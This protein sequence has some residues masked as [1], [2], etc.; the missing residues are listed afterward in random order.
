MEFEG[1]KFSEIYRL[2]LKD[3]FS[4][5]QKPCGYRLG[6]D[7]GTSFTKASY[8]IKGDFGRV[9]FNLG[10]ETK[11]S[12]VY[13]DE[14][15][16]T[17]S[18]FKTSDSLKRIHYFKATMSGNEEYELLKQKKV[19]EGIKNVE[20]KE[21]FEFLCSVFFIANMI[22]YSSLYVAR[23][24]EQIPIPTVSMGIPMSWNNEQ[25]PVYNKALHTA[26][27][28][29]SESFGKDITVMSLSDIYDRYKKYEPL[30][31]NDA[32]K[33]KKT[34]S[35]N[36]TIPEVVTEMN[37]LL[38]LKSIPLGDYCIIDIGGGTADFAFITKESF[39]LQKDPLF[40]CKYALVRELGDQVRKVY[41]Y[42]KKEDLYEAKFSSAFNECCK[43]AKGKMNKKGDMLV[44][45]YLL[46][47]GALTDGAYYESILTSKENMKL[48]DSMNV[49]IEVVRPE[50]EAEARHIIAD[51]LSL[52]DHGLKMLAG[53]PMH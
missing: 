17:L 33:P 32:F 47:G 39:I 35:G 53:I 40:D 30:F 29:L 22:N 49:K 41:R 34:N 10:K 13:F 50:D 25:A 43:G 24:Y 36:M 5:Y 9:V 26:R 7:F 19:L 8:A 15:N 42:N 21:N 37:H 44:K 38:N 23:L 2:L 14:N 12:V 27:Y 48:L 3:G 28:I 46:G 51:Q 11:Y 45:V 1:K 31:I 18:M 52:S 16:L 6:L 4:K 20:L